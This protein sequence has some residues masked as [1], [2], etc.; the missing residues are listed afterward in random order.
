M[1][2]AQGDGNSTRREAERERAGRDE[3]ERCCSLQLSGTTRT[4]YTVSKESPLLMSQSMFGEVIL[5]LFRF[6]CV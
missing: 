1:R 6:V 4:T 2:K 3:R 5:C